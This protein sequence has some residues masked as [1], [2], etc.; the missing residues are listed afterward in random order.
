[1]VEEGMNGLLSSG[2]RVELKSPNVG[3]DGNV[4]NE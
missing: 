1:M 3:R 4:M 2:S